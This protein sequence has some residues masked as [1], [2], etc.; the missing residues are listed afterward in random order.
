MARVSLNLVAPR[1]QSCRF[2]QSVT[3]IGMVAHNQSG[4][5]QSDVRAQSR[6]EM[7]SRVLRF[8]PP[9]HLLYVAAA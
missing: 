9:P 2:Q 1:Q 7:A 6:L 4:Q 3:A 5:N 8:K